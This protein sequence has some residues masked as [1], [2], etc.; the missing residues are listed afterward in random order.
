MSRFLSAAAWVTLGGLAGFL[1][2]CCSILLVAIVAPWPSTAIATA[3]FLGLA[4]WLVAVIITFIRVRQSDGTFRF[5][6]FLAG[7]LVFPIIACVD[8]IIE[9]PQAI[10]FWPGHS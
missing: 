10:L 5:V 2:W 8:A 9:N 6:P 7:T 3:P 1:L 4:I